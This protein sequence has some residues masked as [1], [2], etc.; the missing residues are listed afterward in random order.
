LSGPPLA[1]VRAIWPALRDRCANRVCDQ[2][3]VDPRPCVVSAHKPGVPRRIGLFEISSIGAGEAAGR[4]DTPSAS[5][6]RLPRRTCGFGM[7]EV[8][9]T[10]EERWAS[11]DLQAAEPARPRRPRITRIALV[12]L[13]SGGSRR[14]LDSPVTLVPLLSWGSRRSLDSRRTLL[15]PVDRQLGRCSP[16]GARCACFAKTHRR[17]GVDRSSPCSSRESLR[18]SLESSPKRYLRPALPPTFRPRRR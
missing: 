2:V 11:Y 7:S 5:D 14:S 3:H 10:D 4:A 18:P 13:R 9:Q 8:E 17:G 6:Q 1:F 16:N 15:I 12:P